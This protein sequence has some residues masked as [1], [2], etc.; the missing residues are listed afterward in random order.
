M[1]LEDSAVV[2]LLLFLPGLG[3]LSFFK[4]HHLLQG[5]IERLPLRLV[6]S[7]I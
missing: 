3:V 1:H 5:G 6:L 4:Q 7:L 2:P